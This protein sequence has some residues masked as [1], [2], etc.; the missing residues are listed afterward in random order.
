STAPSRSRL[1]LELARFMLKKILSPLLITTAFL[2]FATRDPGSA[3]PGKPEDVLVD[4][5]LAL[6]KGNV[7][8]FIACFDAER[9][10]DWETDFGKP[11]W[12]DGEN[13]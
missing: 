3:D 8:D 2:Y 5:V 9:V 10:S 7:D 4:M 13:R 6:T 1:G 11:V 12:E